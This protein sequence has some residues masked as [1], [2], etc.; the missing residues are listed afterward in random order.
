MRAST[1][2][3]PMV[4][5]HQLGSHVLSMTTTSKKPTAT[6]KNTSKRA[7]RKGPPPLTAQEALAS[8]EGEYAPFPWEARYDAIN[9]V[10]FTILSQ[11]T[12]DRNSERAFA[13]LMERFDNFE[14]LAAGDVEVIEERISIGGL[15]RI[16]APRI[17]Q[18]LNLILERCGNLDL[19]F[20]REMP[21]EDAKKWLKELPGVGPKTAGIILCFSLGMPAM[22][23]DTHIER[24]VK[25][26]GLVGPK[27]TVE[28][29][30]HMLE[31][32][33]EDHQ[34]YPLHVAL[35][36]HGRQVCKAPRPLCPRCVLWERCPSRPTFEKQEALRLKKREAAIVA[37]KKAESKAK[38]AANKKKQPE[39]AQAQKNSRSGPSQA[40]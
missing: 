37:K 25:R 35:I 7:S 40:S 32:M 9:E 2:A 27:T 5:F 4:S 8:L 38:A 23:V 1:P 22:A 11:H 21:L 12:S 26:L 14:D 28:K 29:A 6:P 15:A 30:Q 17:K 16:K 33:V 3:L 24:V 19:S 20:L 18:V 13:R 34:V 31:E 10:V 36:T 39:K